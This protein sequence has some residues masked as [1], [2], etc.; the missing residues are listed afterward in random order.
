MHISE[1]FTRRGV[2]L[3][4]FQ[5][6]QITAGEVARMLGIS[7]QAVYW[8]VNNGKLHPLGQTPEGVYIF[9]RTQINELKEAEN[10]KA[11][12]DNSEA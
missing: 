11:E 10:A 3:K 8:R 4:Q 2:P 1:W 12:K 5:L 7:R 9:S 6:E